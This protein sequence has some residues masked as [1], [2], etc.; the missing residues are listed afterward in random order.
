MNPIDDI[1][2]G[3][4]AKLKRDNKQHSSLYNNRHSIFSPLWGDISIVGI[5]PDRLSLPSFPQSMGSNR[6]IKDRLSSGH[7][8]LGLHQ[9][10]INSI[11]INKNEQTEDICQQ[12]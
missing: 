8:E 5:L 4:K 9:E 12:Y 7:P 2:F 11:W 10:Y 6:N 3:A 1:I